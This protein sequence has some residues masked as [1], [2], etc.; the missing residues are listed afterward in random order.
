MTPEQR[1]NHARPEDEHE[2]K[3]IEDIRGTRVN[4]EFKNLQPVFSK[5][6]LRV[7]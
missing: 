1:V 5:I 7:S 2:K 6:P 4:E 3:A